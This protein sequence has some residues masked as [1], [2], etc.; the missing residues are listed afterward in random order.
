MRFVIKLTLSL[1]NQ[2]HRSSNKLVYK[3]KVQKMCRFLFKNKINDH[4]SLIKLHAFFYFTT[5]Y[6][7]E[8]LEYISA[9]NHNAYKN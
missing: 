1:S 4:C 6:K 3:S 9:T 5:S 8:N 2:P 7:A